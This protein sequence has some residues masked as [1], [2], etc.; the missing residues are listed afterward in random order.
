M[1]SW[2]QRIWKNIIHVA[3]RVGCM[4]SFSESG[5]NNK[6]PFCNSDRNKTEEER[7]HEMMR[8]VEANDPTSICMLAG[9][10]CLGRA[11]FQQD[12]AKAMELYAKAADLGSS[13]ALSRLGMLYHERGNLKKAKFHFEAAAMAGCEVSRYNI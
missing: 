5:N 7:V 11:G 6:C 3:G 4:H 13:K 1:R 12:H 9:H 8:R 2:Q 10:I